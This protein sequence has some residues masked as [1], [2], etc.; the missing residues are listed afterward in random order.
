MFF[1]VQ[2]VKTGT[3]FN[4]ESLIN[5]DKSGPKVTKES[6]VRGPLKSVS[7]R[8]LDV[9][10]RR[11]ISQSFALLS[12]YSPSLFRHGSLPTSLKEE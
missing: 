7:R 12:R 11:F 3:D 4:M 10:R 2:E 8:F 9:G 1:G 5:D 6:A